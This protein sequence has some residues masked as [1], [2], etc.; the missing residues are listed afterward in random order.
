[1]HKGRAI[2]ISQNLARSIFQ[3]IALAIATAQAD[4]KHLEHKDLE[5]ILSL[6]GFTIRGDGQVVMVVNL[7]QT[8]GLAI[9][10]WRSGM[11]ESELKR[12]TKEFA[13]P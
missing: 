12:R 8:F 1:M 2:L 6:E 3:D 4:V 7:K 13:H 9:E 11:D 10:D 5:D